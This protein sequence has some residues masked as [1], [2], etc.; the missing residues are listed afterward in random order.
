MG[1]EPKKSKKSAKIDDEDSFMGD[2]E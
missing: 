2:D 1:E